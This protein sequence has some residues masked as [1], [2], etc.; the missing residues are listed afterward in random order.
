MI[1][2]RH[3]QPWR[4]FFFAWAMSG[5][6]PG[7]RAA[8]EQMAKFPGLGS[9]DLCRLKHESRNMDNLQVVNIR[10]NGEWARAYLEPLNHP[11]HNGVMLTVHSSYGCYGHVWG[12]IGLVEAHAFL[13]GLADDYV[14]DKLIPQSCQGVFSKDKL[15]DVMRAHLNELVANRHIAGRQHQAALSEL[16]HFDDEDFYSLDGAGHVLTAGYNTLLAAMGRDFQL[17]E[18][19]NAAL[20]RSPA[21]AGFLA[22]VWSPL[23]ARFHQLADTRRQ[24]ALTV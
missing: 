11:T 19:G 4:L 8:A 12:N 10:R 24:G 20:V 13:A 14:V 7:V 17:S 21:V 9:L 5:R 18:L 15:I 6:E 3:V 23:R 1:S 22:N 2:S 16:K